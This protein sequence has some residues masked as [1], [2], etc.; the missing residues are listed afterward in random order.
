MKL[1]CAY[2][3]RRIRVSDG[4]CKTCERMDC[5]IEATAFTFF[6]FNKTTKEWNQS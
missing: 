4:Y 6:K 3:G 2:T 5:A 1:I